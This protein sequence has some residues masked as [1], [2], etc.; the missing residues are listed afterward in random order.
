MSNGMKQMNSTQLQ[1]A[2]RT[3][4]ASMFWLPAAIWALFVIMVGI[5][6]KNL[7]AVKVS[8]AYTGCGSSVDRWNPGGLRNSG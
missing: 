8:A 5:F 1:F 3:Y 4:Q 2:L 7:Q 6:G